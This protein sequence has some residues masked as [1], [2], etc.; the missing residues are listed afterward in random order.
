MGRRKIN[1]GAI[2]WA[3]VPDRSGVVKNN[4]RPLLVTLV[5]PK[6]KNAPAVA[7]CISTRRENSPDDPIIEM[8][9]DAETGSTT[10]LYQWCAMVLGWQV[11]VKQDQIVEVSGRVPDELLRTIKRKILDWRDYRIGR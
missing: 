7:N 8:P 1:E 11:I 6:D 4:P 10:G 2:I 3:R 9:W 5:H